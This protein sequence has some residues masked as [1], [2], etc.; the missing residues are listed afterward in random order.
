[1][2]FDPP[3]FWYEV[4]LL[5]FFVGF[6]LMLVGVVLQ[7]RLIRRFNRVTGGDAYHL[8]AIAE[9][10]TARPWLWLVEWPDAVR[11]MMVWSTTPIA[12]PELEA[13]RRQ[14]RRWVTVAGLCAVAAV[15]WFLAPIVWLLL[16]G[17]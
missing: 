10:Y 15:V 5:L 4:E 2:R 7:W 13:L 14:Y 1:M 16:T 12:H 3:E 11:R 9:R 8:R 6:A 17:G